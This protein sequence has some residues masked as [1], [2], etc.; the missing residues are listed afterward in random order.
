MEGIWKIDGVDV[1]G[2]RPAYLEIHQS[3]ESWSYSIYTDDC[4]LYDGGEIDDAEISI[5][6]ARNEILSGFGWEGCECTQLS[7]DDAI[8]VRVDIDLTE[9]EDGYL[10]RFGAGAEAYIILQLKTT[11]ENVRFWFTGM[12]M[13]D[14]WG[15]KPERNRYNAVYSGG[16]Q[17]AD[18]KGVELLLESIFRKFN[19][20]HPAGFCG[21]SLSVSDIVGIK[22][23]GAAEWYFCDDFGW[24]KL[25]GFAA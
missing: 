10:A 6:E 25:E 12:D 19:T 14:E 2:K 23:N 24:K 9:A 18:G 8:G 7:D 3:D 15:E 16:L 1:G 4:R 13:L 21:H 20:E 11:P 22:R 17:A 5:E